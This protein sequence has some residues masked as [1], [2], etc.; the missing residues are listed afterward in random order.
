[1]GSK[2]LPVI[3]AMV[4]LVFAATGAAVKAQEKTSGAS[5]QTTATQPRAIVPKP[6][7]IA[8][9]SP[10]KWPDQ[11]DLRPPDQIPQ[12]EQEKLG[13]EF[14]RAYRPLRADDIERNK[15]RNQAE[16]YQMLR[17]AF[18][19]RMDMDR[20]RAGDPEGFSRREQVLR[21]EGR[22]EQLALEYRAATPDRK[23]ALERQL[24]ELLDQVFEMRQ[25]QMEERL[26]ELEREYQRVKTTVQKRRNSKDRV[27]ELHLLQLL[28]EEDVFLMW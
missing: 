27:L 24:R 19:E 17:E 16:Y 4:V 6:G 18:N 7:M 26:K 11:P 23:P 22:S 13:L 20:Q 2:R 3:A 8:L 5:D 14:L 12:A 21:Y 25:E 9:P 10:L 28:G 1:M 15:S